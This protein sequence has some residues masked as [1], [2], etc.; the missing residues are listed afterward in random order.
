MEQGMKEMPE[1]RAETLADRRAIADVIRAAFELAPHS[2]GTEAATVER[3]RANGALSL[4]LVAVD[5]GELVGHVAF[6]PVT[7]AG[8]TGNWFGLGPLAVR[9]DRQSGGL[10]TALVR[11]GLEMLRRQ[12][13]GGCVVLGDPDYYGRFGFAV[14][15]ALRYA[16]APAGYFQTLPFRNDRPVGAIAYDSAFVG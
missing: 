4:S 16:D 10:G 5:G 12:G 11:Q 15:P 9:P 3:L 2:S 8:R 13:A 6:S 7:I 14:D 1:I